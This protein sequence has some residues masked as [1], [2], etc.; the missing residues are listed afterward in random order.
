MFSLRCALV[1]LFAG[2]AVV[3]AAP[4]SSFHHDH[5]Q[6]S[7]FSNK[8]IFTPPTNYT[9]PRVLYSRTVELLDGTLLATWENYSP[10]PP[11]VY[12]PI[13]QSKDAG[14]TW[15]EI[16]KVT[17]QVN[18][19]GLRY[20]PFLYE[21]PE[22]FGGFPAGTVLCAGNSIPTD[23]SQTRID[24][25]AS[26]DQGRTWKFVSHVAA[27]GK[28]V[29][30]NGETPIWEPFLMMYK[31]QLVIYYSDQRDPLHGQKLVH[32]TSRNVETWSDPVDD[33]SYS[34]YTARPG[35]TTVTQLP[36]G[37]YMM[38]YEYGGGPGFSGYSFPVYYRINADPLK[39]NDSIG[40]PVV[41]GSTHPVSSPYVTWSSVGGKNGTIIVSSGTN[42]QIF[43]NRALG[44]QG[45][46]EMYNTPQPVAYTR[47]LRVFK[48]D[49]S[50]LLIM[51]AG[52]LPPS[53]TNNV[54]L[55]VIDLAKTLNLS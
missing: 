24:V 52:H 48:E 11:L 33:V 46:W 51:G 13:Y 49:Q 15:S 19:W 32:Q 17:D 44:D 9:D 47:H 7:T 28:A 21:L 40:Y 35:M 2:V 54:S 5:D 6:I 30:D 27:G 20:Q 53:T 18:G 39:F 37:R 55:S 10:E 23:L 45:K 34:T 31:D 26:V 50:K 12:F 1:S 29:P 16:G 25:Y 14:Q 36:D 8:V 38:T 43:V 4:A 22:E 41:V 42:S 3:V